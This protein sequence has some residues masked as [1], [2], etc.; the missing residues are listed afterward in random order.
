MLIIKIISG[1]YVDPIN[2]CGIQYD[3]VIIVG[4]GS[5]VQKLPF[6]LDYPP[7]VIV[8][9]NRSRWPEGTIRMRIKGFNYLIAGVYR[10]VIGF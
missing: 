9:K 4:I 2:I 7:L 8:S 10:L 5:L 1:A 6:Y 3:T